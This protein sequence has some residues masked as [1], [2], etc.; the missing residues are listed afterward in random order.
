MCFMEFEGGAGWVVSF[1]IMYHFFR[2]S[3]RSRDC[4]SFSLEGYD[5][6]RLNIS[7]SSKNLKK[8]RLFNVFFYYLFYFFWSTYDASVCWKL[9]FFF[10]R[11]AFFIKIFES[12]DDSVTPFFIF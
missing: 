4:W 9:I 10:N 7:K 3:M 6:G 5:R 8:I 1:D 11:R 12:F 2:V